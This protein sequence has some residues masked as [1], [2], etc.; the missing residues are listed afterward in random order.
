MKELDNCQALSLSLLF[1][2]KR[3]READTII[4]PKLYFPPQIRHFQNFLNNGAS[5][6]PTFS[7]PKLQFGSLNSVTIKSS[8]LGILLLTVIC[9]WILFLNFILI[10]NEV[11]LTEN[12]RLFEKITNYKF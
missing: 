8:K 5:S 12:E 2:S 10:F 11:V 3:E 7:I 4:T 6:R 9:D 1:I